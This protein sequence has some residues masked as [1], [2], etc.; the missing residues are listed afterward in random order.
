MAL[1][2]AQLQA[3]LDAI[4]TAIGSAVLSVRFPDGRQV[5]YRTMQELRLAKADIEDGIRTY[6]GSNASKSTL[7]Q[8]RRGDGPCGPGFPG[9]GHW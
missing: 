8:T 6:G 5:T 4:N 3:N 9:W 2:L 7:G 1:S